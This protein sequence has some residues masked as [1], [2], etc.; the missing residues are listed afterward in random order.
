MA[1]NSVNDYSTT[2]GNNT[3]VQ[4]IN[5]DE[6]MAPSNVN[7]AMRQI[8]AHLASAF[9]GGVT[10]TSIKAAAFAAQT[11]THSYA[12][13]TTASYTQINAAAVSL[14]GAALTTV[15]TLA[16]ASQ[17]EAEGGTATATV[18]NPLRTKQAIDANV[19]A[20]SD[21]AAGVV[22]LATS[23]EV[24]TGTDTARAV[25]PAGLATVGFMELLTTIST[26]SGSSQAY[27]DIP[28]CRALFVV[29]SGVSSSGT[30]TMQLAI[31]DDNGSNYGTARD[32]GVPSVSS[33]VANH[34]QAWITGTGATATSKRIHAIGGLASGGNAAVNTEVESTRNGVTNAL[35][36][37]PSAGSF[38][39]G[40]IYVYGW[41]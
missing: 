3:D 35:R 19:I 36:F 2:A 18:M 12:G 14:G 29:F 40:T 39:A 20:A 11:A 33:A 4:S 30:A 23:A 25:T 22:E 38:D 5:I 16:L 15:A 8:M 34:I 24:Q 27:T 32:V 28:K 1:K 31:S 9:Q 13:G 41:R 37:S 6:G 26:S 10:A 17:V 21:S 7:N